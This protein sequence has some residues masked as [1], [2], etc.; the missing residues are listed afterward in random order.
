[1]LRLRGLREVRR[2]HPA[3]PRLVVVS[4]DAQPRRTEDGIDVL[5][6]LELARRP[7]SGDL[8]AT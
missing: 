7:W 1:M 4:P 8:I 6:A 2:D 3:T 5:P